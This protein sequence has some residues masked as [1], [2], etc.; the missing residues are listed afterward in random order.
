M[1]ASTIIVVVMPLVLTKSASL[2]VFAIL[3]F[4]EM[5]LFAAVLHSY[6]PSII[7]FLTSLFQE[8]TNV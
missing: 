2:I 5:D 3:D 4:T 1:S 6:I 8:S 7:S